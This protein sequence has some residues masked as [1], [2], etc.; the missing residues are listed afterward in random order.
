MGLLL[1]AARK[2]QLK[3]EINNKNYELTQINDQIKDALKRSNA[4]QEELNRLKNNVSVFNQNMQQTMYNAGNL[5]LQQAMQNGASAE[6]L[7]N[8]SIFN[9]NMT[10][11]AVQIF[12]N[13][14]EAAATN[15][16]KLELAKLQN[17]DQELEMRKTNIETELEV[18]KNEYSSY[19]NAVKES[20]KSSA[21]QFGLA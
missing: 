11:M 20:A 2:I 9:N 12:S 6:Q 7:N 21:P 3:R 16:Q 18:L 15:A 4:K 10:S 19:D 8:M 13:L 17:L 5:A 1:F 14:N